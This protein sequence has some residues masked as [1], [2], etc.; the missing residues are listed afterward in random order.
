[1]PFRSESH[2]GGL[3]C[4]RSHRRAGASRGSWRTCAE[5][6]RGRG[7]GPHPTTGRP[8]DRRPGL[9]D[10]PTVRDLQAIRGFQ[11]LSLVNVVVHKSLVEV[12]EDVVKQAPVGVV[13]GRLEKDSR[14]V[15]V[16]GRRFS[17]LVVGNGQFVHRAHEVR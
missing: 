14:A 3:S 17:D 11:F 2:D 12:N 6:D 5:P 1:M 9:A 16:V 10:P 7:E 15:N 8:R 4:L 13:Q